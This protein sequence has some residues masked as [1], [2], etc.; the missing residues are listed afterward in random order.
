MDMRK[1][2]P[3]KWL[4]ADDLGTREFTM[5]IRDV[6]VENMSPHGEQ[7]NKPVIYFEN[8]KKGLSLNVTNN[9]TLMGAFGHESND[10]VGKEV[11]LYAVDT[12]FKGRATRGVRVMI[13][14][15]VA[16]VDVSTQQP[17]PATEQFDPPADPWDPSAAD[18]SRPGT[19]IDDEIPF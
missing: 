12:Q 1:Q 13:P 15:T 19:N 18:D 6:K 16:G 3:S 4:S 8:A 10:W 9:Q 14:G 11:I 2:F 5:T 7:D 17:A